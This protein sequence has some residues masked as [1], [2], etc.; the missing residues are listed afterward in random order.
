MDTIKYGQTIKMIVSDPKPYSMTCIFHHLFRQPS[1]V[2]FY[3]S[4]CLQK[5]HTKTKWNEILLKINAITTV[6]RKTSSIQ[7]L[8]KDGPITF[9]FY[10][11]LKPA[12]FT[13][14]LLEI[15]VTRLLPSRYWVRKMLTSRHFTPLL[16][17]SACWVS[18][19]FIVGWRI[20]QWSLFSAA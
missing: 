3:I 15:F 10:C 14:A 20:C 4:R 7:K 12:I 9:L 18:L 19:F 13:V 2:P 5:Q 1:I 8:T 17:D 6:R 11:L 16:Y